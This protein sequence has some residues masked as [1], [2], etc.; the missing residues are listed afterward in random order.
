M[1]IDFDAPPVKEDVDTDRTSLPHTWTESGS[2]TYE[3]HE[4]EKT[5]NGHVAT[6]EEREGLFLWTVDGYSGAERTLDRAKRWAHRYVK[7]EHWNHGA[8]S[9]SADEQ[10]RE[11]SFVRSPFDGFC[12]LL[13]NTLRKV[14]R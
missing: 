3:L 13:T 1:F 8:S 7:D 14:F 11:L 10:K 6:I 9:R 12:S 4:R 5:T 2:D